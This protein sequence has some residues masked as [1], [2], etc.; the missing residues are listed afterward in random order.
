MRPRRRAPQ[1]TTTDRGYGWAHQQARARALEDL[2]DGD[3][4]TRCGRPMWRSEAA[5]LHLDHTDD[6][7]GYRGLAHGTCNTR[8]GQAKATRNRAAQSPP[9][10][11]KR[12]HSR[13]W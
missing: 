5:S 9:A 11:A 10:P 6:R 8:A 2:R 4:C 3:P 7:S 1:P 12:V 13:R